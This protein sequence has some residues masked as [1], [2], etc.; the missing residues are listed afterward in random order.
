MSKI[1][2]DGLAQDALQVYP[3]D[4]SWAGVKGLTASMTSYQTTHSS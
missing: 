4:N 3:Y 2:N 1:A